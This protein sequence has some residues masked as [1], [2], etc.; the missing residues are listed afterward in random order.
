MDDTPDTPL[1]LAMRELLAQ[2]SEHTFLS[3]RQR[4]LL[5]SCLDSMRL[6]RREN[7]GLRAAAVATTQHVAALEA[8]IAATRALPRFE[9]TYYQTGCDCC[10][11]SMEAEPCS[12]GDYVKWDQLSACCIAPVQP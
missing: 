10:S 4:T 7:E 3:R 6:L 1:Q 11:P 9:V 2:D 8:V 5:F 12:Y